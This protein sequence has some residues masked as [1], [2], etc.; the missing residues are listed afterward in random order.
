LG[1]S[2]IAK[3]EVTPGVHKVVI[4]QE[5]YVTEKK[6]IIVTAGQIVRLVGTLQ[7]PIEKE[8]MSAN[9]MTA[10]GADCDKIARNGG[11]K[12]ILDKAISWYHK[13]IELGDPE[14]MVRL[15]KVYKFALQYPSCNMV[16]NDREAAKWFRKAADIGDADG[17]CC[18]GEMYFKGYGVPQD[19]D[20]AVSL[21][22][23]AAEQNHALAQRHLGELFEK[24]IGV[25]KDLKEAVT[26]YRK[27]AEQ[28]EG[29]AQYLL[30]LCYEKGKGVRKDKKQAFYW[31]ERGTKNHNYYAI[32]AYEKLRFDFR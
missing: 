2:P 7:K 26:W 23:K 20:M 10:M 5:N 6:E 21:Y 13:A 14:A 32:R 29:E 18:L 17:Q 16:N 22:R 30:G 12:E 4:K 9:E 19:Y 1:R 24:G 27:A 3:D 28:E 8:N 15:G 31:Y 25:K 11:R